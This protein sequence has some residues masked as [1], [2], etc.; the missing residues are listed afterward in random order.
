MRKASRVI[1]K[2][3]RANPHPDLAQAYAQLRYGDAA[4]DRLKRV[5]ALA[6]QTSDNIEG[7]LAL[8]RAALDAR[9]F[10]KARTALKPYLDTP[11][12]RVCL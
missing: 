1:E 3:W 8:A 5:E 10:A 12:K 2:A 4:R 7:A 11:T 9:D 6:R